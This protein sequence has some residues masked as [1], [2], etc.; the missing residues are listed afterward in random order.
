MPSGRKEKKHKNYPKPSINYVHPSLSS[1]AS[2]QGASSS[3]SIV[4]PDSTPQ[5][6]NEQIEHLRRTQGVAAPPPNTQDRQRPSLLSSRRRVAGP[7]PPRSWLEN[8]ADGRRTFKYGVDAAPG[9]GTDGGRRPARF[10]YF[11]GLKAS[12]QISLQHQ[13]LKSLAIDYDWHVEYDH[14]YLATL[15][16]E[17]KVLLLSY[18]TCYGP[19]TGLR[20]NGLRVLFLGTN[21]GEM[22]GVQS[23]GSAEMTRLDLGGS[24]GRVLNLKQL[25]KF[26]QMKGRRVQPEA[27]GPLESWDM[28]ESLPQ[29]ISSLLRF[30]ALT[31]LSLAYPGP[32]VSWADLLHFSR[33]LGKVKHLSL[34][35]WPTPTLNTGMPADVV[36][37]EHQRDA[38]EAAL[39]DSAY[40][41]KLLSRATPSLEYLSL[42]G[43]QAWYR[44]LWYGGTNA[45][46]SKPRT[47]HTH[48]L[49]DFAPVSSSSSSTTT[50]ALGPEWTTSWR[51][52]TSISLV[53]APL[54]PA[55]LQPYLLFQLKSARSRMELPL[56]ASI[57]A[58]P[59]YAGSVSFFLANHPAASRFSFLRIP[60]SEPAPLPEPPPGVTG[61]RAFPAPP[62]RHGT[63]THVSTSLN[64]E[65]GYTVIASPTIAQAVQAQAARR[66]WTVCEVEAMF[67]EGW[68]RRVRRDAGLGRCNVEHGWGK[69]EL[70]EVGY[71]EGE[72][73]EAGF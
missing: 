69:E 62:S 40:I 15:P 31:H 58:T 47:A 67:V 64:T 65:G 50:E 8:N 73:F 61:P 24:V 45:A 43:C 2:T 20:L 70:M 66:A 35:N 53:Q 9:L 26:W 29:T 68:V 48:R 56:H 41:L 16:I 11:P 3:R 33:H 5:T 7:P 72:L 17:L 21:E 4:A 6:V 37:T 12:S 54:P 18:I 57:A 10:D 52:L 23:T 39:L 46:R 1:R 44:S 55:L 51:H 14:T 13:V 63:S 27:S 22:E 60:L 34:A 49:V 38:E 71:D 28:E 59:T 19:S 42:D 25:E 36:D 30:P 32:N